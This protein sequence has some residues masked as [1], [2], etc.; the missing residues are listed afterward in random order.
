LHTNSANHNSREE[1][2]AT[3][4]CSFARSGPSDIDLGGKTVISL[5]ENVLS[6]KLKRLDICSC[7]CILFFP[8][9]C[10]VTKNFP[11]ES[12]FLSGV[13]RGGLELVLT[14]GMSK[15]YTQM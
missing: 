2:K 5:Y 10:L 6:L 14:D 4:L 12:G 1:R 7:F 13:Q 9:C 3:A 11:S 15:K 8:Q